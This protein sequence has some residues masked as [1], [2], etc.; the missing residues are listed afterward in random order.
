[1]TTADLNALRDRI[2]G[3]IPRCPGSFVTASIRQAVMDF[4][5]VSEVWHYEFEDLDL[6]AGQASYA[7]TLPAAMSTGVQIWRIN[8]ITIQGAPSVARYDFDYVLVPGSAGPPVV[9]DTYEYRLVFKTRWI[10]Q[11]SQT[12]AMNV[13]VTLV[14]TVVSGYVEPRI[15]N[16]WEN[17]FYSAAKEVLFTSSTR[18]WYDAK[19]AAKAADETAVWLARARQEQA[20][21]FG[22]QGELKMQNAEDWIQRE[23]WLGSPEGWLT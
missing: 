12:A 3:Q 21:Q 5:Q 14:P 9:P 18:P 16:Q 19:A 7:L 23:G 22:S 10:P 13:H 8:Y 15:W 1:M 11:V 2:L 4:L 17:A 6:V 20:R